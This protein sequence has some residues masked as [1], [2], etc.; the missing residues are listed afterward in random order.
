[1]YEIYDLFP[2]EFFHEKYI[3]Q[4]PYERNVKI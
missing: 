1:L 2:E 4:V 3:L